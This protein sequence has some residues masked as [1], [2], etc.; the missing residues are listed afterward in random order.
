MPLLLWVSAVIV[1]F[2]VSFQMLQGLQAPLSSLN[3]AAH[4][5]F[6]I[7]RCRVTANMFGFAETTEEIVFWRGRLREELV[8]LKHEYTALI[9][10]GR[11]EPVVRR[12]LR[13]CVSKRQCS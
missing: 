13:T 9:Y 1:M 10:G 7:A 5:R 8:L 11:I 4:V 6:R 12:P 2:G 3:A